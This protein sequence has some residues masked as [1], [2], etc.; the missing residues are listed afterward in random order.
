M[1]CSLL[2][3]DDYVE[4]ISKMIPAWVEEGRRE[5]WDHRS[6]WDWLKYNIRNFS[7]Q[8]SQKKSKKIK[9]REM[10]LQNKYNKAKQ[11]FENDSNDANSTLLWIAQEELETFYEKKVEGI[12]KRSQARWYEH[13]ER[14]CKYFLNL[15]KRNHVQKHIRKLDINGFLTKDP[16]KILNEQKHSTRNYIKALIERQITV[17]ESH[18]F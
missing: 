5:L 9:E 8:H 14:S 7:I 4:A 16:L 1:N 10:N 12:T 17:R 2:D 3:D 13:G 15:E 6:V 18:F 11:R